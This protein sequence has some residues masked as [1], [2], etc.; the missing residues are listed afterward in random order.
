MQ[1]S[2]LDGLRVRVERDAAGL[3]VLIQTPK[4]RAVV[5]LD[6][7]RVVA[8]SGASPAALLRR[9]TLWLQSVTAVEA[10]SSALTLR[11]TDAEPALALAYELLTDEVRALPATAPLEASRAVCALSELLLALSER[12]AQRAP[13]HAIVPQHPLETVQPGS[14]ADRAM[15]EA[16]QLL[17]TKLGENWT[18]TRLARALGMSRAACARRFTRALGTTPLRYLTLERMRLAA[19]LLQEGDLSLAEI[20]ARVGYES[21]FAFS[22]AFKRAYGVPP[23]QFRRVA[24]PA[25]HST[26][27]ARC[28]ALAA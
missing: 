15:E 9:G 17:K 8:A 16:A 13:T 27:G 10:C 14:R 4:E 18:V 2:A 22:R 23:G 5:V 24:A 1:V 7:H 21:E 12:N 25:G 6:G 20:A 3:V 28:V 26:Q 11:V 19:K